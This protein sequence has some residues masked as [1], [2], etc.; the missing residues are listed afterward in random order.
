[1]GL[2]GHL[3]RL[4]I[5]TL[6]IMISLPGYWRR[7][8]WRYTLK[9]AGILGACAFGEQGSGRKVVRSQ[10]SEEVGGR[11]AAAGTGL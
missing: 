3:K 10:V 9:D 8:H 11:S 5:L 6:S 7:W 4:V 1:M 2:H